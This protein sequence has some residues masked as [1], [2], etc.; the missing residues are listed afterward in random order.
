MIEIYRKPGFILNPN[1]K[2]VSNILKR[3]EKNDGE[4]PCNNPGKTREDRMCP[5]KHYR[6]DNVC[7]CTLYVVDG[8]AN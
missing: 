8:N 3:I 4:C 6:E 2:I 7:C 5:C 1:D